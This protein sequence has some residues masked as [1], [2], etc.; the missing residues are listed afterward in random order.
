MPNIINTGQAGRL[1]EATVASRITSEA[2]GTPATPLLVSMRV[3]TIS[4]CCPKVSGT[5]AAWATNTAAKD[6][7]NVV[8]SKLNE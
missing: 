6:K 2:R 5:P 8:P 4:N 3:N 1:K 7:Y